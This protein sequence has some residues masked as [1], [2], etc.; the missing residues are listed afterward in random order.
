[1]DSNRI[2]Y[3]FVSAGLGSA[4][5]ESSATNPVFRLPDGQEISLQEMHS[6]DEMGQL[7]GVSLQADRAIRFLKPEQMASHLLS[8]VAAPLAYRLETG[9]SEGGLRWHGGLRSSD[10]KGTPLEDMRMLFD[11]DP[12]VG[13]SLQSQLFLHTA[14]MSLAA[15]PDE[16]GHRL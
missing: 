10:L 8:N 3:D 11:D 5:P 13:P 12:V 16:E 4:D 15:L 9:S 2:G 1:G 7:G 14:L 6:R